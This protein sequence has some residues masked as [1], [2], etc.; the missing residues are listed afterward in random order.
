VEEN[1][2]SYSDLVSGGTSSCD[3]PYNA[4]VVTS[5]VCAKKKNKKSEI[6]F[7]EIKI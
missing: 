3:C 2:I 5:D 1:K 6:M 7:S 4:T